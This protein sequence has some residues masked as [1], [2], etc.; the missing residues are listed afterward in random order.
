MELY[1]LE[2][3]NSYGIPVVFY[4]EAS[5]GITMAN[6]KEINNFTPKQIKALSEAVVELSET[7]L[8]EEELNEL[9]FLIL[10]DVSGVELLSNHETE[11]LLLKIKEYYYDQG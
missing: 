11:S 2:L 5:E 10:E 3:I 6:Q 8:S 4:D 1:L 9:I 7:D